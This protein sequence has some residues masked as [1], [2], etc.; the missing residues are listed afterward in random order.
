MIPY[1]LL[2][3]L[4]GIVVGVLICFIVF[5]KLNS[6]SKLATKYDER[7]KIV[8]GRSFTYGF[9]AMALCLLILILL[10]AA[11]VTLPVVPMV[12]YITTFYVGVAVIVV[13]S[14]WNE[15]YFGLNNIHVK[16]IIFMVVLAAING[17]CVVIG[18]IE[19]RLIVDGMMG[20]LYTNL[21]CFIMIVLLLATLG[22][23]KLV[24]KKNN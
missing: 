22:I 1:R 3:M 10:D 16:W 7:Q 23:K 4:T 13:H 8:R 20:P 11:E 14:I 6:D 21:L 18:A 5:K 12:N 9:W 2:G 15:A 19:G 17:V 24:D